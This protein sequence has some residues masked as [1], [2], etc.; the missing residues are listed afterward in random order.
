LQ[1]RQAS[2]RQAQGAAS[3]LDQQVVRVRLLWQAAA[4]NPDGQYAEEQ[5]NGHGDGA[6]HCLGQTQGGRSARQVAEGGEGGQWGQ[7]AAE[8]KAG[9]QRHASDFR[10]AEAVTCI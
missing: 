9:E 2:A 5:Q 1:E 3:N 6:Q 4:V 10:S 8:R 7:G